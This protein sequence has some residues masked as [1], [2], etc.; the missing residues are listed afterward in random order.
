MDDDWFMWRK[1]DFLEENIKFTWAS[2]YCQL[3]S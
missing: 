2:Q 1:C 3:L